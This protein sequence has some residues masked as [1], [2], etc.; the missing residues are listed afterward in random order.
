M[1]PPDRIRVRLLGGVEIFRDDGISVPVRLSTKKV[2]A[3]VAFLAMSR[4]QAATREELATLLWGSCSDQQARQSLRQALV[5]LRKDLRSPNVLSADKETIR[6]QAGLWSCDALEFETLAASARLEDLQRAADLLGGELLAGL[7]IGEEGFDEWLQ[8]QRNRIAMTAGRVLAACAQGHDAAG[9][10]AQAVAAAER[11]IALDPLREDWQRL[12]LRLYARYRGQHDA[13]AQA[14]AFAALLRRELDVEPEPETSALVERIRRGEIAPPAREAETT[15]VALAAP[16]AEER[17]SSDRT[18]PRRNEGSEHA[19][20]Q[21]ENEA[22]SGRRWPFAGGHAR[23]IAVA[24]VTLALFLLVTG[25]ALVSGHMISAGVKA[26]SGEKLARTVA[27]SD[28]FWRPPRLP[29]HPQGEGSAARGL[30]SIA[31]LP[32]ATHGEGGERSTTIAAVMTDD[33]TNMLSRV[34]GFRVISRQTAER[35]RGQPIDVATI[36]SE[37]R[38]RYLLN[39]SARAHDNDLAVNVELLDTETRLRVWSGRFERAGA[40]RSSIESDVVNSLGRELEIEVTQA[41]SL[42]TSKNPDVHE[43][44]YKG[45]AAMADSST[46]GLP[47]LREAEKYLTLALQQDPDNA[48][49]QI[50]LAGYHAKMA[51]RLFVPD[52]A[53]HLA[54]A[55]TM[56]QEVIAR[57]PEASEAHEFMGLVHITRGDANEAIR[58]F[59][60]AIELNSS[61]APCYGQLGRALVRLGRF[62]EGLEHIHYAMRLSPRDPLLPNWLGMAGSAE[63]GLGHY[64]KAIEYLDR[65]L[66]F[67]PSQPRIVL[68]LIAAQALAGNTGEARARLVRLQKA[69]PHLTA[70]QLIGRFFGK[71]DV[72]EQAHMRE[73]LRLALALSVDPWQSPPPVSRPVA[74]DAA[75]V[76]KNIVP[77]V[78]L[79]FNTY[80]ETAG[81]LQ[82][83]ADLLTDDLIN[84]LSRVPSLRVISRLTSSSL[85]GQPIDVAALGAELQVRYVLEGSMRANGDKLRVNVELVDPATRLSVWS[86]R[87]ERDQGER[88]AVRDEIVGRLARE[89]QFELLPIESERRSH[90]SDADALAQRG[91]AAMWAAYGRSGLDD[92]KRAEAYFRQALERD[93]QNPR[94]Q[95]GL[96]AYH[97]NIG[98]QLL[99]DQPAAHL[100]K[101]VEL[102]RDLVRRQPANSGAWHYLGLA[103]KNR[104]ELQDALESFERSI[105][106]TPSNAGAHAHIG[107]VLVRLGRHA[108]GLEHIRY[109][110]RL[111]PRDP[112]LAYWLDFAGQAELELGRDQQAIE[113]FRRSTA[114]N[115]DYQRSWAGL[116]AAEALSGHI[117]EAR[118][119]LDRLKSLTP[120]LTSDQLLDRFGRRSGRSLRLREGLEL[121]SA[122][123]H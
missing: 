58:S 83:A 38:T 32:F 42:R 12:A 56:L 88:Q 1:K 104:G 70:E 76:K 100:A 6:L 93:P 96:G 90:D 102:L 99:D 112:N 2:Y 40:D 81:S 67:D 4:K 74:G 15:A 5:L 120:H 28:D 85:K 8:L 43:L 64:V 111:S 11:L 52:P 65:A 62:V 75:G 84:M 63:V 119:H 87:I 57:Y 7:V 41:E 24:C 61:C 114:L 3:L 21:S 51:L 18:A 59:E 97:A 23:R 34:P 80:G 9:C 25:L 72:P 19:Q 122:G 22:A 53:P 108:E 115:P 35:Y 36:G 113:D 20:I 109:A 101:A 49:A 44:I 45:Y 117:E 33:L 103:Q 47:A 98:S 116:A 26:S 94:A 27:G 16:A 110:M 71:G 89:L 86:G 14:K 121:A 92:F 54:K 66:A 79:P 91:W 78:V 31:V 82:L 10:G 48:R 77:I 105:E 73:G 17:N 39:G 69:F 107:H 60:Q 37:L 118:G 50:G 68:G 29:S 30:V 55:E 95:M 123:T 106:L 46:S 13:L